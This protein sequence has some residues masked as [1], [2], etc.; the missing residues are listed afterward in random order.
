M[1]IDALE[2]LEALVLAL[3]A[4][5]SSIVLERLLLAQSLQ[6]NIVLINHTM[7]FTAH[8]VPTMSLRS[9][10][11][12]TNNTLLGSPVVESSQHGP[13]C[14][15]TA[16]KMVSATSFLRKP[17]LS[18]VQAKDNHKI[19]RAI[20]RS[21]GSDDLWYA[22][23]KI[24]LTEKQVNDPWLWDS[25]P[26]KYDM[27]LLVPAF[28][29]VSMTIAPPNDFSYIKR[30]DFL[31]HG[32]KLFSP[33]NW[34]N[35]TLHE[36]EICEILRQ[37]P[38]PNI[39]QYRGVEVDSKGM[40]SGL[41]F[42]RYDMSLNEAQRQGHYID[43]ERCLRD[44]ERAIKHFHALG[45]VHC[46]IKH[47]NIFVNLA[48]QH[49]ALGD[50]DAVHREGALLILK[51]GTLG[52]VPTYEDTDNLA[53]KGIDWYSFEMLKHWLKVRCNTP[54]GSRVPTNEILKQARRRV[55]EGVRS[56]SP[57][58]SRSGGSPMDTTP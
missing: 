1:Y 4:W 34:R 45:L 49:F 30:L 47:D 36:I 39:C 28:S 41:V 43:T 42:D 44:I 26:R 20:L 35:I 37:Y 57:E 10:L 11:S 27:A 9:R 12:S 3:Q 52:W 8:R 53:E 18:I 5:S 40:V 33:P 6:R 21:P 13:R 22:E 29:E 25:P 58:S 51:V 19:E 24:P 7:S 14:K 56:C 23:T 32:L 31:Q 54:G 55:I 17:S 48:T 16:A 38:H 50:F 2:P 46:D 15:P